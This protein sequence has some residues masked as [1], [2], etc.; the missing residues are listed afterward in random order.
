VFL[1]RRRLS[2]VRELPRRLGRRE[3]V[4]GRKMQRHSCI[5]GRGVLVRRH[6]LRG[7]VSWRR[8]GN[9]GWVKEEG[10]IWYLEVWWCEMGLEEEVCLGR[11]GGGGWWG[12]DSCT[13]QSGLLLLLICSPLRE[14]NTWVGPRY[15]T[16]PRRSSSM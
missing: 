8:W 11:D 7:V 9:L 12:W 5:G 2:V 6:A 10:G 13:V 3:V 1:V 14:R 16:A 15:S 4:L